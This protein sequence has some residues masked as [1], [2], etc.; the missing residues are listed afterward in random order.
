[1][2]YQKINYMNRTVNQRILLIIGILI[3]NLNF[4]VAQSVSGVV[5]DNN[6]G[7]T[8]IGANVVLKGTTVGTVTDV[9][10]NFTLK[11][12][13]NP[14]FD[15]EI[16]FMGYEKQTHKVTDIN[17]KIMIKLGA[18]Q[19]MLDAVEISDIRVSD[20]Q[21]EA[22]LTVE[23]M[24]VLAI[25]ETPAANFYEGLGSL[26][27]VDLT[28]ASIGFKVIN[29]RGFN[30]TS[31]VRSLQLIDG[32]DNQSPGLNFSLGNFLGA[33]ELDV[34]KVDLIAGASSAFYG[35]G[36]FNGVINMTTKDPFVFPGFSAQV[37]VG[38]R[39]LGE[40]A[41]RY[42]KVLKD[43]EG[44]DK[45][46]FKVN[47]F[48]LTADD[49]QAD[50]YDPTTQSLDGRD[51]RGGYDAINIYGDEVLT[52]GNDFT[53]TGRQR[54]FPGLGRIYRTGYK[55]SDLVNYDTRN[56]KLNASAHYKIKSDVELIAAS[57]YS[58]GN[59]V[60]QGDNRY[61]LRDI[62]FWQNRLELRKKDKYFL[63]AY[64]TNE[65]AGNTF[66]AVVTAFELQNAHKSE[67]SWYNDY[68]SF[69]AGVSRP[70]VRALPGYPQGNP[71]DTTALANVLNQN[72]EF[73][74]SL[75][76]QAR[77]NA[78]TQVFG[79]DAP[80]FEPG[81][82]RFDSAYKDIT[83]RYFTEGGSR[84][85]DRSA[86]Y[87]LHGEYIFDLSDNHKL[88]TGANGR[89]YRPNSRGTIFSDTISYTR[90]E[91]GNKLD[92]TYN[93]IT[94]VEFGVYVGLESK[95]KENKYK[96]TFTMRMDKNQN[97]NFIFSPAAS[98]VYNVDSKNT[99][100]LSLSSAVRN[101]TMADQYFY[102]DVGRAILLGNLNGYDSLITLQSFTDYRNTPNLDKE[103]LD[104][105]NVDPVKP[106]Q[107][108]TAEVGYRGIILKDKVYVDLNYYYSL[109]QN[110]I[111]FIIGLD[112]GFDNP[113]APNFP[114]AVQAYRITTNSKDLVTTQGFSA[115]LNYF[116]HKTMAINGNYTWNVLNLRNSDDPIIPAY[117]TPEHKFNIGISG[118]DMSTN[119][120]GKRIRNYGF[121]LNYKWIEGFLFE[122]SPQFT[123][124][125]PTY[126][127]LDA[128][129]NY[130]VPRIHSTFKL[131]A[132]NL[133][134]NKAF[135]VY[136]GPRIGRLA[137]FSIL[138]EP[139]IF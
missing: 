66:D 87:H 10:G 33:S 83:S 54:D 109:Y 11:T 9:N 107:V 37:K 21:K 44:N 19:V 43:K 97:F 94:N 114:S 31:P 101:P 50:N 133:L 100:R 105:F 129:I 81:T 14:P 49:W 79:E 20:K 103:V 35:P 59:T 68:R 3:L 47:A 98:F 26:K 28:S 132:S 53:S 71:F 93:Q 2:F 135:Q 32:V 69:W 130:K 58:Y 76:D 74:R 84:F 48:Y 25:K 42:A 61:N 113:A 106:E 4:I 39:S 17:K 60:Y 86:L 18:S 122:G 117:N 27:G 1:M 124:I 112:V 82:A 52:L 23:S 65:D 8:I 5:K 126:D 104:Y 34:M 7:E 80:F 138:F 22:A 72:D 24:D 128:Q 125:V 12:D 45:F 89:M 102:Y 120:F 96:S 63:R 77:T 88:I 85:F 56:L 131:G 15:L 73:I 136:G 64:A 30:S 90:D 36:A 13:K 119:V 75:H 51:N 29:T 16:S 108:Y 70:Q 111:G 99:L 91:L 62:Q 134:N 137:Y 92:S 127:M 41:V 55:E 121:S 57:S 67:A 78:N 46:A 40:F 118:R 116:F 139:N 123:G 110:F 38:E 95:F 6:S 115:G